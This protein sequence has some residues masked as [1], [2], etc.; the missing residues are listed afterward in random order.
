MQ[1]RTVTSTMTTRENIVY[2]DR[3][4]SR[5]EVMDTLSRNSHSK[6]VICDNGLDKILG[7]IESHTLLTMYLQ[8]ENVVLTD[9]NYSVKPYLCL[10][11][12]LF[13][14]CWDCLNLLAKILRLL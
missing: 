12:F 3:T 11:R 7:Y 4:F 6:I 13:T 14:K 5:Q 1:A 2:L 10:I 9:P 8:N